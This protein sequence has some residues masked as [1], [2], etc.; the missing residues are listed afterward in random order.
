M[1]SGEDAVDPESEALL[2]QSV[3]L[4]LLVVLERLEPAERVALVLHDMFEIPFEEIA[5][6]M[7]RSAT[8]ARQLASRARR[9]VR[10]VAVVDADLR[11]QRTVVDA[12]SRLSTT[13][14]SK[15]S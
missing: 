10:G 7:G 3:G 13:V 9:R 1:A 6:I 12:S 14:T 15:G 4:A 5:R 11:S 2:A 8:A